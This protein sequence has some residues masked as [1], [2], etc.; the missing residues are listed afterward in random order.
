MPQKNREPKLVV[1]KKRAMEHALLA[2]RQAWV[3][4]VDDF[5]EWGEYNLDT[6][7][8]IIYDL[9]GQIL[10]YE[11]NVM[12]GDKIVGSTKTAA[13]QT[14]GSP[15]V[16]MEFGERSWDFKEAS[17]E[18]SKLIQKAYLEA[19]LIE[20]ELVCYSYPK[21]GIRAY[22]DTPKKKN[23][24]LIYDIASL[25]LVERYDEGTNDE[26]ACRSFYQDVVSP[27]IEEREKQFEMAEEELKAIKALDAR[28]VEQGIKRPIL[29]E[30]VPAL[31]PQMTPQELPT[32]IIIPWYSS[33][34]IRFSP[35]CNTHECFELY[36]QQTNVYC[37]VATGQM[38]L[39][40]YKYHYTQDE[41]ATAMGTGTGGT[42]NIGQVNGYESLSKNC[43]DATY[44][45]TA[46]WDEA[47]NEINANRPLKSGISG[48][49]RAC[50]G[51]MQ[52]TIFIIGQQPEKWLK[53]YDPSPWNKDICQGGRVYWENWNAVTH[54]NF[55]YL[56]HRSQPC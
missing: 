38:L 50:A 52:R 8:L 3:G 17:K 46:N 1:K 35:R 49:A 30:L 27:N 20:M 29:N 21:I 10:F 5:K 53:I 51:W 42:S 11:F 7:P 33:K 40:F 44:D 13:S 26:F 9:N 2:I 31:Q 12:D 37:A 45:G 24:N 18:V 6:E 41:I 4:N 22:F 39:D 23:Q 54:T 28:V 15:V 43:L 14:I 25:T 56:R 55:I 19:E 47:R 16:T 34:T 36:A 32:N 48:H